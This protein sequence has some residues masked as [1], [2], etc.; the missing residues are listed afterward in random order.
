MRLYSSRDVNLLPECL[1]L[2]KINAL[3]GIKELQFTETR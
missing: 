3:E 2:T 1:R